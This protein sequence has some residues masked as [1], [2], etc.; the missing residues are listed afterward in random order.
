MIAGFANSRTDPGV[1]GTVGHRLRRRGILHVLNKAGRGHATTQAIEAHDFMTVSGG[2]PDSRL[3][4]A[5]RGGGGGTGLRSHHGQPETSVPGG[6]GGS[7]GLNRNIEDLTLAVH[8]A[9]CGDT[10][11]P[12]RK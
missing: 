10:P 3:F 5:N 7:A 9:R 4:S 12:R 6:T 8:C 2:S 11:R 1:L